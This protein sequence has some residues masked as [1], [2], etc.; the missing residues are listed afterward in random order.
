MKGIRGK[1]F[2]LAAAL[3]PLSLTSTS[4]PSAD[5]LTFGH[6]PQRTGWAFEESTLTVQNVF[7]LELKWKAQLK[8]EQRALSALTAPVVAS[9][10]V[11]P[12]G[13]KTLAYVAGSSNHFF[14]LDADNGAV[15][16]TRTFEVHALAKD[17]DFWSCPNGIT[18][19]PT[20]G[21]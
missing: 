12:S 14:A 1:M 18:A 15:I 8:N 10:V 6:D 11:T 9:G 7:E 3:V 16:W 13:I 21:A 20:I 5:W 17:A 4:A 2:V 19:T